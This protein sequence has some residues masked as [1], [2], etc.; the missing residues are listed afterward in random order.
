M[1]DTLVTVADYVTQARSL[2]QD[3]TAQGSISGSYRY[4]DDDIITALNMA[5]YEIARVR[6][7]MLIESTYRKTT[8]TRMTLAAPTITAYSSADQSPTIPIPDA[9]RLPLLYFIVGYVQLRDAEDVQ[10]ARASQFINK[11]A[12]QLMAVQA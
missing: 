7:D 4:S 9:Y 3:T 5:M 11:F 6:A 10:D 2:L 8:A 1:A 12:A